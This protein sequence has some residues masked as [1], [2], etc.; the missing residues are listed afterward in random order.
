MVHFE[1]TIPYPLADEATQRR[2]EP[3]WTE[4]YADQYNSV[5]VL[6]NGLLC[7]WDEDGDAGSGIYVFESGDWCMQ[8]AQYINPNRPGWSLRLKKLGERRSP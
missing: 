8:D 5:H 6:P 3:K 2:F 7:R 4:L 1:G